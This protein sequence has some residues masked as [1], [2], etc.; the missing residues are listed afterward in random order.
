MLGNI[1]RYAG[2]GSEQVNLSSQRLSAIRRLCK[3]LTLFVLPLFKA[4]YNRHIKKTFIY[5]SSIALSSMLNGML[6]NVMMYILSIRKAPR[7]EPFEGLH[8][9]HAFWSDS[10]RSR[11]DAFHRL[12]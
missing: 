11:G 3:S 8:F 10:Q 6:T 1:Y 7:I 4:M 12:H 2:V 5:H 9:N